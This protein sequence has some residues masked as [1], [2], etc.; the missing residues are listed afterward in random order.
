MMRPHPAMIALGAIALAAMVGLW[1]AA[2]A[3]QELQRG[4]QWSGEEPP[5]EIV[6]IWALWELLSAVG[7]PALATAAAASVLAIILAVVLG[8][9]LGSTAQPAQPVPTDQSATRTM[10]DAGSTRNLADTTA[11]NSS[12]SISN[13][14]GAASISMSTVRPRK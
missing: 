14:S 12:P 4:M 1:A 13:S 5:P 7:F 8:R 3:V 10:S 2:N 9:A 6:R 11:P